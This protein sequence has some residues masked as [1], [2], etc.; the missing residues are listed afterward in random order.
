M[1]RSQA[2]AFRA[3]AIALNAKLAICETERHELY[4]LR[5]QLANSS[6][7]LEHAVDEITAVARLDEQL[8][9]LT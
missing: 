7:R 5:E 9:V 6:A 4:G 1:L 8:A 3:Q 2:A